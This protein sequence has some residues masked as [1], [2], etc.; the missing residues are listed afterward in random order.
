MAARSGVNFLSLP[1][2]CRPLSYM[3][4]RCTVT[5]PLGPDLL[6]IYQPATNLSTKFAAWKLQPVARYCRLSEVCWFPDSLSPRG[7]GRV[8]HYDVHR[9]RIYCFCNSA[10]NPEGKQPA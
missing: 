9:L 2:V 6:F 5:M 1:V 7:L 8:G 4:A 10:T 3:L